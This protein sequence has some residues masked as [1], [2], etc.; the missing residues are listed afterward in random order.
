M[1]LLLTHLCLNVVVTMSLS[2]SIRKFLIGDPCLLFSFFF[3]LLIP[4]PLSS[5]SPLDICFIHL[6]FW[7]CHGDDQLQKAK[8]AEAH[9]LM[10]HIYFSAWCLTTQWT[11]V[12][13]IYKSSLPLISM[14]KLGLHMLLHSGSRVCLWDFQWH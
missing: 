11:F 13:L 8:L 12:L 6:V 10:L 2:L 7:L 5:I 4:Y 3:L 1:F 14:K 9:C